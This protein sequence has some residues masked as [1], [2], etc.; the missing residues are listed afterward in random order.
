MPYSKFSKVW[1][2]S[3]RKFSEGKD[4]F[5]YLFYVEFSEVCNIYV[6]LSCSTTRDQ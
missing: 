1:N 6:V 5:S 3:L 4:K 2:L